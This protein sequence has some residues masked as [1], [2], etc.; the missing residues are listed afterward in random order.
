[1]TSR[2]DKVVS[3]VAVLVL[4]ISAF[5]LVAPIRSQWDSFQAR[6]ETAR[7]VKDNWNQLT[8]GGG[9]LDKGA[10]N[11]ALIEFSDY[12]C[13]FCRVA[14]GM[15]DTIISQEP[16]Q[17]IV[18]RHFPITSIHPNA[19]GAARAAICAQVQGRF[20]EMHHY[21]MTTTA[22]QTSADWTAAAKSAQ[23]PSIPDF[24]ACLGSKETTAR[25]DEDKELARRLKISG[26]PSLV[27]RAGVTKGA[28]SIDD[29]RLVVTGK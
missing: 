2:T 21:L 14:S 1:M 29:L 8:A 13:P 22:W 3:G 27:S 18:Y 9:R 26:T 10:K 20:R 11:V 5:R 7:A 25:L 23:V 19:E 15:L 24:T 17:G 16:Q 12:E 6:R 28:R 4:I